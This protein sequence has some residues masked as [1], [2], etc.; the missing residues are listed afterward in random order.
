MDVENAGIF[1]RVN[2]A[3]QRA[4]QL[5]QGAAPK[6]NTRSR[7]PA[8]IAVQE[9]LQGQIEAFSPEE[10]PEPEVELDIGEEADIDD[11]IE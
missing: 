4:R 11:A 3:A 8:A 2:I 9:L 5:M 10:M 7:K 1:M 6:V